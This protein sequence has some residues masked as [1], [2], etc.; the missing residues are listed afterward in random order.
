MARLGTN[1]ALAAVCLAGAW[2]VLHDESGAVVWRANRVQLTA[3]IVEAAGAGR[4]WVYAI[5]ETG[6]LAAWRL[7]G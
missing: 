6:R 5:D 1:A 3:P 4:G 2:L 7:P